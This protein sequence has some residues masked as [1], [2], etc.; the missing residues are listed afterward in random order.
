MRYF[1]NIFEARYRFELFFFF[2][3]IRRNGIVEETWEMTRQNVEK[4]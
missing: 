1:K 3:E 2:S 4:T